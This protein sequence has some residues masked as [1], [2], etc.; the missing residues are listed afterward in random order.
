MLLR[1]SVTWHSL[2][3]L[4]GWNKNC[5]LFAVLFAAGHH[6]VTLLTLEGQKTQWNTLV[7]RQQVL[8]IQGTSTFLFISDSGFSANIPPS[9]GVWFT[10]PS[11]L[12]RIDNTS[13]KPQ[14]D[15]D[16]GFNVQKKTTSRPS[17]WNCSARLLH[18]NVNY[19]QARKWVHTMLIQPITS[20]QISLELNLMALA[21]FPQWC[22]AGGVFYVNH[23]W[24]VC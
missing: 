8:Y 18:I 4:W 16:T 20:R 17:I 24:L 6:V 1:D 15:S 13:P 21:T 10:P 22:T 14:P 7:P 12:W 5:I 23:E 2:R 19:I 3:K 11:T 9:R